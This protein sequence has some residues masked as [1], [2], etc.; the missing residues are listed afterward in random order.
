MGT[1]YIGIAYSVLTLLVFDSDLKFQLIEGRLFWPFSFL[2]SILVSSYSLHTVRLRPG[3][4]K[5]APYCRIQEGMPQ[6]LEPLPQ[7]ELFDSLQ[8]F[9]QQS[10]TEDSI[11]E[12]S[13]REK[14]T[15]H[16]NNSVEER[17]ETSG[18][19]SS[20]KHPEKHYCE[21]CCMHQPYRTRHCHQCEACVAKFDHHCF[22]IGGCVGE[23]NHRKF[24]ATVLAASIPCFFSMIYVSL[25]D[26]QAWNAMD[27]CYED[28]QK[29]DV[30]KEQ[31]TNSH[32]WVFFSLEVVS[33]MG[34]IFAVI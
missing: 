33:V 29:S 9:E 21:H 8:A 23:L 32:Y 13:K 12:L 25:F 18:D 7:S 34:F 2:V 28:Y 1:F 22:W 5:L 17:Q 19:A 4:I 14:G 30:T 15:T 20:T 27:Y 10:F 31:K 16:S 26:N 24:L 11:D 3:Y 6:Q